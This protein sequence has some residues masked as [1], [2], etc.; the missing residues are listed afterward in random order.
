MDGEPFAADPRH[1]CFPPSLLQKIDKRG[2]QTGKPAEPIAADLR[3]SGD[4]WKLG[5][6]KIIAGLLDVGLDDLVQRDQQR[7]QKRMTWIAAA[8]LAGMAFTSGMSVFAI[9]ARDAARDERRAA[10]GLV[11][12][13]LGDLKDELQPIGKA[14]RARQSRRPRAGFLRT[15][16]PEGIDG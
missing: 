5:T 4:G 7:R 16:G 3:E 6:L 10:E 1:E 13:M 15:S 11:G 12:F 8:S 14:R 9:N 2:K